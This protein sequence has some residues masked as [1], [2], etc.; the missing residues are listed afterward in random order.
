MVIEAVWFMVVGALLILMAVMRGVI[1]RLPMTGAMVYLVAGFA[2]GPA[3]AGLLEPD[4]EGNLRLLRVLTEAGLVVSLFAIGMHLRVPLSNEL[5]RLTLR[6]AG[7][8]MI[9]TIG[10]VYV[11]A[12]LGLGLASGPALLLAAILAPTDPVLANEL[13]VRKAGDDE[14]LRFAL[15][16]E[17]GCNDGAAYPFALIALALCGSASPGSGNPW[18]FAAGI[19]W[20]I[21]S[22]L[23]IGWGIGSG[24]V[25][26]VIRLRTRYRQALGLEGFIAL[27]LMALAYGAALLV[28][29]YAFVAVFAAGVALRRQELAATGKTSPSKALESVERGEREEAARDPELAHAYMAE[30]M[31][32]FAL[33][34]ERLVEFALMLLIGSVVSARIGRRFFTGRSYGPRSFCSSSPVRSA[35]RYRSPVPAWTGR[36]ACLR[37][38]SAYEASAPSTTCSSRSNRPAGN[39]S[40]RLRRS[41]SRRLFFPSSFRARARP[42]SCTGTSRIAVRRN[43]SLDNHDMRGRSISDETATARGSRIGVRSRPATSPRLIPEASGHDHASRRALFWH[44]ASRTASVSWSDSQLGCLAEQVWSLGRA[45]AEDVCSISG[46][47]IK[48]GDPV[49][50]PRKTRPPAINERSVIAAH[51]V[52]DAPLAE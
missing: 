19:A 6:L 20:G 40:G 44:D 32:A 4:I 42:R 25:R 38:G 31:M 27:G 13:R 16:S 30:T 29:G 37:D 49:F 23:V 24:V 45:R 5:W 17:G 14:P 46:E 36:S 35:R 11:A 28:H 39:T 2:L 41:C 15:S 34:F 43:A 10:L 8:A 1:S 47:H 3:G 12:R 51:H 21:V 50:R 48:R 18:T 33:E 22:A 7:P 26:L 52:L 9:L